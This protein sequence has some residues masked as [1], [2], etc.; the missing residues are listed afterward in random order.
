MAASAAADAPARSLHRALAA[1]RVQFLCLGLLAGGW[2]VHVPSAKAIFGLSELALSGLLLCGGLGVIACLLGAGHIVARLGA[3]GA[4]QLGASGAVLGLGALLLMPGLPM[5]LLAMALWG[6]AGTLMDMAINAEGTTLEATLGR[7][8]MSGLHGWFSVGGMAG[9]ALCGALLRWGPALPS[10]LSGP[11]GAAWQ[12][13]GFCAAVGLLALAT[14]GG[15]LAVHPSAD[16]EAGDEQAHFTWPRGPLLW[17]G[18]LLLC[19]MTAEGVMYDWSVLYL[20]QELGQTQA[21]A[22][23]AYIAFAG[24]M[25][26]AR[27]AGDGL[28]ARVPERRLLTGGAAAAA[29][30]MALVLLVGNAWLAI[31][32]FAI[33]GAGLAAVAPVL[34][35][36]ATRVPGVSRAAAISAATSI[37]YAGFMIGPSLIGGLAQATS[38]T[39]ALAVLVPAAALVAWGARRVPV[40]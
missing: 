13:A 4:A 36:A 25:A 26:V 37:G 31:V 29:V 22:S 2:G 40:G 15:M 17:I 7:P 18:L 38:L 39:W 6:A 28:R 16:G 9:A 19:G 20:K 12:M 35:N 23:L 11:A 34:F 8:V 30:S 14:A 10:P 24:A 5:A 3:R 33:A 27:F 21:F 32:G 1:T